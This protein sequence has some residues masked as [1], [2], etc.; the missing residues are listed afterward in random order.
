[1]IKA[2][3]LRS[4]KTTHPD[5]KGCL[6]FLGNSCSP[7]VFFNKVPKGYA[8]YDRGDRFFGI[9]SSLAKLKIGAIKHKLV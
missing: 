7:V 1:M 9:F 6:Y 2:Q 5:Y 8:L 4:R 3:Y